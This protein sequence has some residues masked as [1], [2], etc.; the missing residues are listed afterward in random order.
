MAVR[1]TCPLGRTPDP[2]RPI[3][4]VLSCFIHYALA[5]VKKWG[6]VGL[7]LWLWV[8]MVDVNVL[9]VLLKVIFVVSVS[10]KFNSLFR[11]DEHHLS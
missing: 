11:K 9:V 2:E 7:M 6:Y 10:V 5:L 4:T 1:N 8:S 3:G